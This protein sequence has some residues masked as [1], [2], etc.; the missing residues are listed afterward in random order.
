VS[1]L[2]A[3][4][5][6]DMK[7]F[8]LAFLAAA[9]AAAFPALA[10][11]AAT[12]GGSAAAP[13]GTVAAPGAVT[14]VPGT[15]PA[16]P[17]SLSNPSNPSLGT[18]TPSFGTTNPSFGTPPAG[19]TGGLAD[20][21]S[22]VAAQAQQRRQLA[23]QQCQSMSGSAQT[24]CVRAADDAFSRETGSATLAQGGAAAPATGGVTASPGNPSGLS[25]SPRDNVLR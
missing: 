22:S 19:T 9:C 3:H 16:S 1:T 4:E 21:N 17:G 5:R 14:T 11:A 8:S 12:V 2:F 7:A 13:G 20:S 15:V 23:L 6:I 10:Q 18:S 24:D 25:P